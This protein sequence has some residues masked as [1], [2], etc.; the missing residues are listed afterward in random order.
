[1]ELPVPG[2]DTVSDIS[3]SMSLFDHE[4]EQGY[5]LALVR[6]V[7]VTTLACISACS[8]T[9]QDERR[10]N[11]MLIKEVLHWVH[12]ARCFALS[13]LRAPQMEHPDELSPEELADWQER[14]AAKVRAALVIAAATVHV[15]RTA[16]RGDRGGG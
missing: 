10:R 6:A 16:T 1:M 13:H 9:R 15:A 2:E 4:L 14:M 3:V 12:D 7:A 8:F 5:K 11:L